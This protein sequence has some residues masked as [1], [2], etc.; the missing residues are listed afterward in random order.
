MV[1]KSFRSF[2]S[3]IWLG[4]VRSFTQ[5]FRSLFSFHILQIL[6]GNTQLKKYISE[7]F[8]R[9]VSVNIVFDKKT[10][11]SKN[12]GFVSVPQDTAAKLEQQERHRLEGNNIFFRQTE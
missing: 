1:C 12:Y 11:I 8:G 7:Q 9:V 4:L 5:F 2:L 3:Q 10:G 6:V